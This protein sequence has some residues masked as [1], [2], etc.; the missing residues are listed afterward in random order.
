MTRIQCCS[1]RSRCYP[2][3]QNAHHWREDW[4]RC[5]SW[6][7]KNLW[8]YVLLGINADG[9][10]T[11]RNSFVQHRTGI[12]KVWVGVGEHIWRV[13]DDLLERLQYFSKQITIWFVFWMF[14]V[15]SGILS[16]FTIFSSTRYLFSRTL[17]IWS[18][19]LR[20]WDGIPLITKWF[21]NSL[22]AKLSVSRVERSIAHWTQSLTFLK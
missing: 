17:F 10:S 13:G 12:V 15:Y 2:T 11:N 22:Q 16:T 4:M 19:T 5:E 21:A 6:T 3:P 7:V 18:E 14:S 9:D 8:Q 20:T 1:A